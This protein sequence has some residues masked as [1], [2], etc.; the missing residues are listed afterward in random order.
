ML[1][2][3][4]NSLGYIFLRDKNIIYN[5]ILYLILIVIDYSI[6]I[7]IHGTID[8]PIDIRPDE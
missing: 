6:M 2:V 7:V 1:S 3:Y 4:K 8:N 5:F